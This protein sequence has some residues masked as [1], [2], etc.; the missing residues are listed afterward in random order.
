[1]RTAR[2]ASASSVGGGP[3]GKTG[4]AYALAASEPAGPEWE[5]DHRCRI[6]IMNLRLGCSAEDLQAYFSRF[7]RLVDTSVVPKQRIGFLTFARGQDGQAALD[8]V[9]NTSVPGLSPSGSEALRLEFRSLDKIKRHMEGKRS[10]VSDQP[11]TRVFIGYFPRATK[12]AAVAQ[13]LGRY[14]DIDEV[15]IGGGQDGGECFVFVQFR[16][17]QDAARAKAAI[18]G[19]TLPS[20]AG[21]RQLIAA[22]KEPRRF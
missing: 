3:S 13:E 7:G 14:G 18:H 20:L 9:H 12:R 11:T 21:G 19:H 4:P 5:T 6:Y 17:V 10:D 16:R 1:M 15:M 22:F 8:A 2:T